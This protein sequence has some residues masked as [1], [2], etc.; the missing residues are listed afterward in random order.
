METNKIKETS[1]IRLWDVLVQPQVNHGAYIQSWIYNIY[2]QHNIYNNGNKLPWNYT[3]SG[4]MEMA[5]RDSPLANS[6]NERWNVPFQ[7]IDFLHKTFTRF[8]SQVSLLYQIPFRTFWIYSE[9][10]SSKIINETDTN[11][12]HREKN[13]LG[14]FKSKTIYGRF[15]SLFGKEDLPKNFKSLSWTDVLAHIFNRPIGG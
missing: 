8:E 12:C 2:L 11:S 7:Q 3:T 6:M 4:K 15:V 14:T 9:K 10:P 5:L 13:K 1:Q